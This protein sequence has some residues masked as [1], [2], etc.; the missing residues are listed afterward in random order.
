MPEVA[1]ATDRNL[2]AIES[3][4]LKVSG[5]AAPTVVD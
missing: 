3:P 5:N 4:L 2:Q 1:P